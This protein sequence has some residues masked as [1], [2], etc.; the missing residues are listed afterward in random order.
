MQAVAVLPS[1]L[2]CKERWA[3]DGRSSSSLSPFLTPLHAAGKPL[4]RKKAALSRNPPSNHR[5]S[6]RGY[7]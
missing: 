3:T 4:L 5:C 6:A 7:L 1:H 2:I